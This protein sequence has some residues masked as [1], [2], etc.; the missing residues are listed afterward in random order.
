MHTHALSAFF[1]SLLLASSAGAIPTSSSSTSSSLATSTNGAP[2]VDLGKYGKYK[3]TV[4]NN[5]TV[6]AWKA[7]PYAAPPIGDLR[8]KAP[9]ALAKQNSTVQDVSAD[10]EG[11]PTACV[12]FGTTSFVGVNASPGQE[13]CLKLWIWAPADVKKGDKLPV[14][15]YSHGGGMQNSQ[16]PNNDFGDWVG[17]D[18]GFIAVNANYRLGALGF[19]NSEGA[20]YEGET[21]NVGLLDSR[22]AVDWV[23]ENIAKFG[24][25]P[26]NI[27]ISGQSGGGG[28]IMT[29]LVLYDG[30]KPNYQKAIP[31][32]IQNYAAY[33]VEELT[34]RNDAFAASVNCT[35]SVSTKDG[36][37]KQLACLRRLSS[38][39]IRLAALDFSKTKQDNGFSWPG[40]L[41]SIDG[42]TLTDQPVRLF[43]DG[44]VAK[45]PVISAH[46]TNE[47]VRL[48][49]HPNSNFTALIETT[50]GA[51]VTP[52]LAT[53]M[54]RVYPEPIVNASV[55]TNTYSNADDRAYTFLNENA[56]NGGA[57]MV[58]RGVAKI[59]QPSWMVRFNSPEPVPT[60][61]DWY[62]ASHSSDNYY[63]QN[64]TTT[65]NATQ[66]AVAEEWRAYIS[67]FLK[68]S[69]PNK[70]RLPSSPKWHTASTDFRYL[71]RLVVSQQ[72]ALT[73]NESL[74]TTSG[75]EIVP[76]NEWDR[77]KWWMSE[78]VVGL[79]RQ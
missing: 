50:I 56:A 70:A 54:L 16:S 6:H 2:I 69:N 62:G 58:A 36:A 41:P 60:Y 46:V 13:D 76:A 35:D 47:I 10:F 31:R 22:F 18:K 5:G 8:F 17:Q 40:W 77:L 64:A 71:P 53:E 45:V 63:L 27:A 4:Q 38:E 3:G 52:E 59:G 11:H 34:T 12:Q 26:H 39:T 78:E 29:Q 24:G 43:R 42:K 15:V 66:V 72:L 48:N 61:P 55:D 57:F 20:Q 67:S 9:R 30:K 28:T 44:K 73:A 21:A 49:P 51:D 7:I 19:Y 75:M 14:Q 1:A 74:P 32:S 33:P 79:S 23:K 65:M 25:D 37:K 68:H